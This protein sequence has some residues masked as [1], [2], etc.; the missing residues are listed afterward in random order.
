MSFKISDVTFLKNNYIFFLK[1]CKI[2]IM[3]NIY[4]IFK[5]LQNNYYRVGKNFYFIEKDNNIMK[6]C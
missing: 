4:S 2:K 1:N 3:T 5:K 6:P